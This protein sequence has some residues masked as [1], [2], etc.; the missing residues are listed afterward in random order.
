MLLPG[1]T[2]SS[3]GVSLEFNHNVIGDTFPCTPSPIL[4]SSPEIR[5]VYTKDHR[6]VGN[7]IWACLCVIFAWAWTATH[8][9]VYGYRSTQWQRTKAANHHVL[10]RSLLAR[11]KLA[12][13]NQ[14]MDG[15]Q[16]DHRGN[17]RAARQR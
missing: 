16:K 3:E 15:S 11:S 6:S 13:V 14:A 1:L 9:N 8:P 12:L 4:V 2:H 17:E 10:A 7:V 5:Y